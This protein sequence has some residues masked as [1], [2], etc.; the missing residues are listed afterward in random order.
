MLQFLRRVASYIGCSYRSSDM[1]KKAFLYFVGVISY[2]LDGLENASNKA[3]D[4]IEKGR[5]KITRENNKKQ[6]FI[7]ET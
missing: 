4:Q 7:K 5:Q 2:S 6:E 3:G 1:C